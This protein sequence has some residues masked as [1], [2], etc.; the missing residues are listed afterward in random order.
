MTDFIVKR[1]RKYYYRRRVPDA[2]SSKY[3][4]KTHWHFSL[5]TSDRVTALR[6][7]REHA[8]AHDAE[9]SAAET[10]GHYRIHAPGMVGKV[11]RSM[12]KT[13]TLGG[14]V[15]P[16]ALEQ[17]RLNPDAK[18]SVIFQRMIAEKPLAK[19]TIESFRRSTDRW[20][21]INGDDDVNFIQRKHVEKY[22]SLIMQMPSRPPHEILKMSVFDQIKWAG[23][24]PEKGVLSART[25]N[26]HLTAIRSTL[27]FAY[28]K[29]SVIEGE[30]RW[31]NPVSG[32]NLQVDE[33]TEDNKRAFEVE[34]IQAILSPDFTKYAQTD[35][36]YWIPVLAFYTGARLDEIA[37]TT[38]SKVGRT[39]AG[40]H[41]TMANLEENTRTSKNGI[42]SRTVP[43]HNAIERLGFARFVAMRQD[44]GHE[45]LFDLDHFRGSKRGSKVATAF[46]RYFRSKGGAMDTTRLSMHSFRHSFRELGFECMPQYVEVMQGHTLNG[47]SL[48]RYGKRIYHR[49]DIMRRHVI[50]KIDWPKITV[51]PWSPRE[52]V[53]R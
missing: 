20:Y 34:E 50:E 2:L 38:V 4:G 49:H 44:G 1:G 31:R 47:E 24:H 18:F 43:L 35:A 19:A 7:A 36:R 23:K 30:D 15:I 26:N 25:V 46:H 28:L 9:I 52:L 3:E 42:S 32:F 21:Q 45:F 48:R 27:D 16:E 29:T 11:A 14:L 17:I 13:G 22:K 12:A 6:M 5:G 39:D 10:N 51:T 33:K 40:W 37:Q 8:V 41:V 53:V